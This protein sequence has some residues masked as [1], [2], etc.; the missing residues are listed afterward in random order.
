MVNVLQ[1]C[2][3]RRIL[4]S[5]LLVLY[6]QA[7]RLPSL[8]R[9]HDNYTLQFCR[10]ISVEYITVNCMSLICRPISFRLNHINLHPIKSNQTYTS[11]NRHYTYIS[12]LQALRR[13][14]QGFIS[15]QSSAL[16]KSIAY[17]VYKHRIQLV[18]NWLCENKTEFTTSLRTLFVLF[19]TTCQYI[20]KTR[21]LFVMITEGH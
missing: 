14:N 21:P 11:C 3:T 5:I 10:G 16:I 12:R 15:K 1:A 17:F 18:L 20:A 2:S 7:Q 4:F 9:F 8:P 6:T 13:F 19:L